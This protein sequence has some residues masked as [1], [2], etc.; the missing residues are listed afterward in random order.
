[1]TLGFDGAVESVTTCHVAS[2]LVGF[3][4]RMLQ[5]LGTSS[6]LSRSKVNVSAFTMVL[7]A[8]AKTTA[9]MNGFAL[10]AQVLILPCTPCTFRTLRE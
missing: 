10:I 2:A 8:S 1:M 4:W 7:A 3:V 9:G 5:P 6:A